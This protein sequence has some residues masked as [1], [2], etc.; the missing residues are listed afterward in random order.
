MEKIILKAEKRFAIDS[1]KDL[2]EAGKLPWVVY[3]GKM[4]STPIVVEYS[5]FLRTFRKAWESQIIEVELDWKKIEVLIHETQKEP[6]TGFFTHFDLF[7][8]TR[9][10][11]LTTHITLNFTWNSEAAKQW[12]IIEELVKEIEVKCLPKD[13]VEHFDVDLSKLEK[14]DDSIKVEDLDIDKSKFEIL[15]SSDTTIAVAAKP[16]VE[17]TEEETSTE[18]TTEE[19]TSTEEK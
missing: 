1:A 11:K 3:W 18:E 5:D 15:T 9:W 13:L 6:V 16:K 12:A 19:E 7:A 2:R 17:K 10:E 14:F 8:L 4:E